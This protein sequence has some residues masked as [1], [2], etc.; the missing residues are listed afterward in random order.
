FNSRSMGGSDMGVEVCVTDYL[1][2]DIARLFVPLQELKPTTAQSS[3]MWNFLAHGLAGKCGVGL[4]NL[5]G[6]VVCQPSF[7]KMGRPTEGMIAVEKVLPAE[8]EAK[9][10]FIDHTGKTV[11]DFTYSNQPSEFHEGLAFVIPAR[12]TEFDY[13]II[14]KLGTMKA[15]IPKDVC[16]KNPYYGAGY[17]NA[18]KTLCGDGKYLAVTTLTPMD[19]R[20]E[21]AA[22]LSV[23]AHA[24]W[25]TGFEESMGLRGKSYDYYN[26]ENSRD[27]FP[28]DFM[29]VR[30]TPSSNKPGWGIVDS[31]F[32]PVVPPVFLK[33]GPYSEGAELAWAVFTNPDGTTTE[34]YVNWEGVFQIVRDTKSEKW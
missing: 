20:K 31:N 25:V 24:I 1:T 27:N 4:V 33:I 12:S 18:G 10:G 34:G 32:Q 21:M 26:Y 19:Y 30:V 22:T 8:G 3:P 9:W 7:S 23:G 11:I 2:N 5:N 16:T 14:D 28:S 15:K 29:A 17:F 6:K 13:G